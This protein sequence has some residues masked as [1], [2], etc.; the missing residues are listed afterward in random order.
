MTNDICSLSLQQA[1]QMV[2]QRKLSPVELAEACLRRVDERDRELNSFIA[3]YGGEAM[4]SARTAE[5]E[6]ASGKWRGPLHG[7]P[8]AIKDLIDMKGKPTTAASRVF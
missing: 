4:A 7:I 8:V 1:S 2:R 6:I 5:S 3:V